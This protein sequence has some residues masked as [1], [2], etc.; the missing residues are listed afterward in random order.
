MKTKTKKPA[1]GGVRPCKVCKYNHPKDQDCKEP[2]G[3][4]SYFGKGNLA[5]EMGKKALPA[6]ADK[7]RDVLLSPAE[8]ADVIILSQETI[9]N[10][11]DSLAF[12]VALYH[13]GHVE[14]VGRASILMS[15]ASKALRACHHVK[16]P[17]VD[18]RLLGAVIHSMVTR[19][20]EHAPKSLPTRKKMELAKDATDYAIQV[21][22]D[23]WPFSHP[24]DPS[25]LGAAIAEKY[26]GE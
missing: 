13:N 1:R 5:T 25:E 15:E 3:L 22:K 7:P 4:R 19:V 21:V 9:A 11:L 14:A 8:V 26:L 6:T 20:L 18:P 16:D 17:I 12:M 24:V 2:Y 10:A 23:S